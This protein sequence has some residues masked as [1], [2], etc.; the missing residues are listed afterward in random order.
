MDSE[1]FSGGSVSGKTKMHQR[2]QTGTMPWF[3]RRQAGHNTNQS[4][5]C[6]DEIPGVNDTGDTMNLLRP[7]LLLEDDPSHCVQA[8]TCN[9]KCLMQGKM[10]SHQQACCVLADAICRL[11]ALSRS[12]LER[13]PITYATVSIEEM[14][15]IPATGSER[16]FWFR[17]AKR[18][19]LVPCS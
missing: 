6:G 12:F 17:F 15:A 14:R 19:T 3:E 7:L 4:T 13:S 16:S 5:L 2:M 1:R 11:H 9:Q 10:H 18:D 8:A